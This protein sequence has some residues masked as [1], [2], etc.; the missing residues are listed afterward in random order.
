[1]A[2]IYLVG[3]AV[4]D[5]LLGIT[6]KDKDW[7]VVGGSEAEML[8]QNY[9]RVGKDFP[10]FLHPETKEE[11]AL[12]RTERKVGRGYTGFEFNATPDVSLEEDLLRRDLTI[13]A[14]AEDSEGN[15]HDPYHGVEDIQQKIL[16]HVSPAFVEDPVRI[17]RVARFAARFATLGFT[18]ASTTL[19]LMQRMVQAGEVDALVPERVW[20]E[21][22]TAL[23][24]KTPS[25]F[26]LVLQQCGALEKLFPQLVA[27]FALVLN[28]LQI[29][30]NNNAQADIRFA[31][32]LL[33]LTTEQITAFC[34]K[35]AVPSDYKSLAL[36][37][38][39][40]YPV[41]KHLT[42]ATDYLTLLETLDAFRRPQQLQNVLTVYN[43]LNFSQTTSEQV[44]AAYRA[45]AT[46]TA[47]LFL[48]AGVTGKALG[49]KM[50]QA[51]ADIIAK[52]LSL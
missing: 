30:A 26:F 42:S 1:M 28:N 13:N 29:A 18:V 50:A 39:K 9:Y 36:L 6:V 35:L 11:Y 19:E 21:L 10:V 32:L 25:E 51:R 45:A 5:K 33:P 23:S 7:L 15:L 46:I 37:C 49:E 52:T 17:L 4:R 14:I 20:Q 3:G 41:F 22:Q 34:A 38:C 12:A 27:P 47:S 16:R 8:A 40:V 48:E 43:A 24:E 31:A 2:D 44:L